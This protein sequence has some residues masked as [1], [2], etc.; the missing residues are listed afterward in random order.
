MQLAK[1]RALSIWESQRT[2]NN[3]Y[4][5]RNCDSDEKYEN[6]VAGKRARGELKEG[7]RIMKH[8]IISPRAHVDVAA[9]A[10]HTF[11]QIRLPPSLFDTPLV[12]GPTP[13]LG[14]SYHSPF[15]LESGDQ[16]G[17]PIPMLHSE[18]T[19]T[20]SFFCRRG[21]RKEVIGSTDGII[22]KRER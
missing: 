4:A 17:R 9:A 7:A 16:Q 2:Q 20:P 13:C 1:K 6:R 14:V 11:L 3:V 5:M 12:K 19:W 22:E 18:R 21:S 10:E 8:V 15:T